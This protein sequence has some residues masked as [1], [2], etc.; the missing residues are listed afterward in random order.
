[1]VVYGVRSSLLDTEGSR[2]EFKLL[3]MGGVQSHKQYK[4]PYG[5]KNSA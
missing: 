5:Y 3:V 4:Q 1:M 2:G